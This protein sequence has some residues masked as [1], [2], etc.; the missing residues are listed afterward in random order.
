LTA[1]NHIIL[2]HLNLGKEIDQDTTS[3]PLKKLIGLLQAKSGVINLDIPIETTVEGNTQVD[4][5]KV[6]WQAIT[7]SLGN[8]LTSPVDSLQALMKDHD[9]NGD[10]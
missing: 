4:M 9:E 3:L 2:K 5:S 6:V 7:E 1:Q 10:G 8:L